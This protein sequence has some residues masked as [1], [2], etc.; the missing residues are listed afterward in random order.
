MR[1]A[2]VGTAFPAHRYSQ[3]VIT[4][5][6]K[7]RMQDKLEISGVVNRLDSNCGVNHRQ[8]MF[9]LHVGNDPD[10]HSFVDLVRR[11]FT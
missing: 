9:S 2:S 8:I 11:N 6:L 5:A 3:A 4:Q 1:I 10:S 7:E